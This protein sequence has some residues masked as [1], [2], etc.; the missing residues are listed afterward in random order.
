ML[1][2]MRTYVHRRIA[3]SIALVALACIAVATAASL[4]RLLPWLAATHVPARASLAFSVALALAALEVA[5]LVAPAIGVSLELS[6]FACD[7]SL[8]AL[9]SLG[10]GPPRILGQIAQVACVAALLSS[11]TSAAWGWGAHHPGLL[12]NHVL[13]AGQ[14][15]CE[16]KDAAQVPLVHD[17]TWLCLQDQP[18]LV[19]RFGRETSGGVWSVAQAGFSDDL[20]S[21]HAT[22]LRLELRT[23]RVRAA[24][25]DVT[26]TG[27]V[28][29]LV[30]SPVSPFARALACALACLTSA[31]GAAFALLRRPTP[32]RA[33]ALC[34]GSS[35][36]IAFLAFAPSLT[37]PHPMLGALASGVLCGAIPVLVAALLFHPVWQAALHRRRRS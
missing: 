20:G 3:R 29:W 27:F 8:P 31:I 12:S 24:F 25:H 30:A 4:V 14:K 23:P 16:A 19:G 7:G 36:P 6:R 11:L 15:V 21:L 22:D 13:Q 28:P 37:A 10:L 32:S 18:V 34:V 5:L 35:G 1:A 33:A 9:L 17:A 2:P 26:V